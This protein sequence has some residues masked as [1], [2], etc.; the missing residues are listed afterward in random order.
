[1]SRDLHSGVSEQRKASAHRMQDARALYNA[2]RWRGA[3][4][5]AG[6]AIE[7]LLKAKLMEQYG[8]LHLAG[9]QEKLVE[10][11][12]IGES[13]TLFSHEL[14]FLLGL[15]GALPRLLMDRDGQK[16]FRLVNQ[17]VPAWRYNVRCTGRED[18]DDFLKAVESIQQWITNNI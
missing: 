15:T 18:A 12:Q 10:R 2:G 7:C 1:M 16:S 17:W 14:T 13:Q 9:L 4:Y 5:I 8:G 3:M 11:R 6:Y